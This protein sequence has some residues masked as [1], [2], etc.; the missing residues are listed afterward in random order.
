M[1]NSKDLMMR[2]TLKPLFFKIKNNN[3]FYIKQKN[4]L[5]NNDF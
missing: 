1:S 5:K 3:N 2:K 4:I